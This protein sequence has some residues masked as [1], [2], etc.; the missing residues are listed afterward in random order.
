MFC[1]VTFEMLRSGTVPKRRLAKKLRGESRADKAAKTSS[2]LRQTIAFTDE[3]FFCGLT[4]S[5]LTSSSLYSPPRA[6]PIRRNAA[7]AE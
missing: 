5:P 1:I 6:A 4:E 2:S 7:R 3:A